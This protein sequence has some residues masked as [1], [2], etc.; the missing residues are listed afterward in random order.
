MAKDGKSC[1]MVVIEFVIK[2]MAI[3]KFRQQ[4]MEMLVLKDLQIDWFISAIIQ[5]ENILT[6]SGMKS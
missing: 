1:V 3:R 4:P 6:N 5:K 2:R